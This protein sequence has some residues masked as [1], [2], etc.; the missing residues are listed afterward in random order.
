[1]ETPNLLDTDK[2]A[3]V[4]NGGNV[5]T[6]PKPSEVPTNTQKE[7]TTTNRVETKKKETNTQPLGNR[8]LGANTIGVAARLLSR[9]INCARQVVDGTNNLA[10]SAIDGVERLSNSTMGGAKN[11]VDNGM[12]G[13]VNR[14][15]TGMQILDLYTKSL[16]G[17][18]KEDADAGHSLTITTSSQTPTKF[19]K[20]FIDEYA[21]SSASSSSFVPEITGI[22]LSNWSFW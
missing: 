1:M 15:S 10:T 3:S 21:P 16:S 9:S 19:L 12:K 17:I 2:V 7:S 13:A 6:V 4:G 11:I 8:G 5:K 20:S 22:D 14:L 18:S